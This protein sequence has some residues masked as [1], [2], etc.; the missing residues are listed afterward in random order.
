MG[1]SFGCKIIKLDEPNT[2]LFINSSCKLK[3]F[4]W[5]IISGFLSA[6][7]GLHMKYMLAKLIDW[8]E[9]R[10]CSG[11]NRGPKII[12]PSPDPQYP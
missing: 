1:C 10:R 2:K 4:N 6:I 5:L 11:L 8:N 12:C 9:E 7:S 3:A